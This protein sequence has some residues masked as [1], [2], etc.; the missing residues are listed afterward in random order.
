MKTIMLVAASGLAV[1]LVG[2]GGKPAA[3][4]TTLDCPKTQG[5]LTRTGI[6]ADGKAC[7][8]V[9]AAGAEVT[10]QLISAPQGPD[11]ALSVIETTLLA[12]RQAPKPSSDEKAAKG[13]DKETAPAKA[14]AEPS[15]A[16]SAE[17]AARA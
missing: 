2:C 8:Y 4:R 14:P 1:S 10:L 15:E 6:A 5:E 3:M 17:R 7:T 12:N 13:A 16:G 9:T 11:A